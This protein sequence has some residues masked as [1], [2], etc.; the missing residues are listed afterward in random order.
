MG[1][2]GTESGT[3][4]DADRLGAV[5]AELLRLPPADRA[6]LAAILSGQEHLPAPQK[7]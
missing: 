4:A 1:P 3:P 6:R 7:G 5:A 2:S